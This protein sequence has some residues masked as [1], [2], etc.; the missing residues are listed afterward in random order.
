MARRSRRMWLGVAIAVL[1]GV[2][3]AAHFLGGGLADTMRQMH[4]GR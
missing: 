4:G 3:I 2:A 1:V